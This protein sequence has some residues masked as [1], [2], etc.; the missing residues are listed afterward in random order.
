M[1]LW[2]Y[3]ADF[4]KTN[5]KPSASSE[6]SP[7]RDPLYASF[8]N[9]HFWAYALVICA[10]Y[11]AFRCYTTQTP[12]LFQAQGYAEHE[13]GYFY[14]ALAVSYIAG[15]LT[16]KSLILKIAG[17]RLGYLGLLLFLVGSPLMVVSAIR[18]AGNPWAITLPMCMITFG[19][20]MLFPICSANA[21]S[22]L[23]TRRSG[24]GSGLLGSTKLFCA[25]LFIHLISHFYTAIPNLLAWAILIVTLSG[26]LGYAVLTSLAN[27]K[28]SLLQLT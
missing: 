10:G 2:T 28:S 13:M 19:N 17:Q 23:P 7:L 20:G 3:Q 18:Y 5:S 11:T 16:V 24:L 25:A 15:N 21:L 4:S 12:F 27:R 1:L 8:L 9:R 22:A 26:A 14:A 6:S